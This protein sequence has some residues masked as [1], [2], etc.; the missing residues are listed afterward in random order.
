MDYLEECGLVKMDFLGLKT[1]TVIEDA[2]ALVRKKG[3]AHRAEDPSRRTTRPPSSMFCEGKSTGAFQFESS[4]MQGV[5]KKARPGQDR[6]PHRAE[7]PLPARRHGAHRHLRGEQVGPEGDRVPAARAGER[8][9]GDLRRP[10][11]PGAGHGDGPGRGGVHPR[12]G[13]HPAPGHGKEEARGN[14][15]DEGEVPR[16]RQGQGLRRE[17]RGEDL[18]APLRLQRLRLQQEPCRRV[19]HPRLPHHLA[20]G[21][22]S[23]GVH[24]RQLHQRHERHGPPG[25]AHPRG[26]GDG[27]RGAA[28]GRE[29]VAEGVHRREGEDRLRPPGHQERRLGR[30]GRHHRGAGEERARSRASWTSSTAS[31]PTR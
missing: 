14:A 15:Q 27:H 23:R 5:L 17:D 7:R 12:P 13:R 10:R 28:A 2:L 3:V 19:R 16:G 6:G 29:R 8:P 20:E 21:Q 18:R 26:A 25:P 24:R 9:E 1:L 22:P 11:L 4:G 30:G 31:I